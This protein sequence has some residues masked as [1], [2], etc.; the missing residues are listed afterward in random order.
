[1]KSEVTPDLFHNVISSVFWPESFGE[2][3]FHRNSCSQ[4][5]L[6]VPVSGTKTSVAWRQYWAGVSAYLYLYLG[7]LDKA[8]FLLY[9]S[10]SQVRNRTTNALLLAPSIFSE[11]RVR[12]RPPG[13]RA[14]IWKGVCITAYPFLASTSF[15]SFWSCLEASTSCNMA[16]TWSATMLSSPG[17]RKPLQQ[18]GKASA[19]RETEDDG[20]RQWNGCEIETTW[21]WG[22][23]QNVDCTTYAGVASRTPLIQATPTDEA[24]VDCD[25][26]FLLA[27]GGRGYLG[28]T[29]VG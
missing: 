19:G 10:P 25:N 9:V 7:D 27:G 24:S 20:G 16:R 28:R 23:E 26:G 11:K 29:C 2:G 15:W 12:P 21:S 5:G 17:L 13:Q 4:Y 8:G 14:N 3:S 6:T 22:C 18:R 1:M